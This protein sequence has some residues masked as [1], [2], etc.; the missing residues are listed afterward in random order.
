MAQALK[1]LYVEKHPNI[2]GGRAVIKGTRI[3]IWL[4][5]RR[6]RSGQSPEEIQTAYPYLSLS[7]I[8]EALAYAF[9]HLDE[10]HADIEANTEARWR[11]R[12]NDSSSPSS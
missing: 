4:I 8:H 9:D 2:C 1:Y 10:M 3:P 11:K 5:F 12:L 6:Y 7:Q